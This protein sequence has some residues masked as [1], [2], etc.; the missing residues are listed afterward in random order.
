[1]RVGGWL[2]VLGGLLYL[3]YWLFSALSTFDV[4]SLSDLGDPGTWT[5]AVLWVGL[6]LFA[7]GAGL[8]LVGLAGSVED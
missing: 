8:A 6:P 1:M 4:Y 7:L 5:L 2:A 3:I